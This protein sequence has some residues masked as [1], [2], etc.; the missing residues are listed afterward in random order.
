MFFK[1]DG[2]FD[3]IPLNLRASGPDLDLFQRKFGI[4]VVSGLAKVRGLNA[5]LKGDLMS[6]LIVDEP[7]ARALV[8]M[9]I[10]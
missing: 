8:E 1:E 7:T 4:C 9:Y 3:N 6:E 2:S 10:E 5:A